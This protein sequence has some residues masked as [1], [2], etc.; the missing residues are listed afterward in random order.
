[1][2]IAPAY[3]ALA[4]V[5]L[6]R[7]RLPDADPWL[8]RLAEVEEHAT[9][10]H[11]ALA[12]SLARAERHDVAGDQE[13]ALT[14]LRTTEAHSGGWEPPRLLGEQSLLRRA[15]LL[16]Q[17]GELASARV[18]LDRAGPPQTDGGTVLSARLHLRLGDLPGAR[19]ALRR[20]DRTHP[21][22]R[23]GGGIVGA[24]LAAAEEDEDGALDALEDALLAAAPTGL[25]RPF[26]AEPDLAGLLARR[27]E[28]GSAA[29]EFALDLLGRLTGEAPV[30]RERPG[31][32][33]PLTER[34]RIA[35]RYLASSLSNPEIAAQLYVSV[36]TV[37][38]H[39]R[40][41]YR[42]LGADGRRDAVR[43]ARALDLL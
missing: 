9:E 40:A 35:L 12:C 3:L 10:R 26:L 2:Q 33:D 24:L 16:A 43:R 18:L 17:A 27:T 25:R 28:Q 20:V 23:A 37:K 42:K 36:N 22:G 41:V 38:T 6:D 39:Q 15:D 30:P 29:S 21:R 7:D 4:R 5:A 1:M 8:G 31:L 34:E 19:E 11:V 14:E 13:R 32:V